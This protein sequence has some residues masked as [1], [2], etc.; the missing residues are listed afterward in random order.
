MKTSI[1]HARAA[2]E[3]QYLTGK[4]C[5]HGHTA[6]R[7]ALNGNCTACRADYQRKRAA[8]KPKKPTPR[9]AAKAAGERFYTGTPCKTCGQTTRYSS[10]G[11]CSR[12]YLEKKRTRYA[13]D[14]DYCE[15][16][17]RAKTAWQRKNADYVKLYKTA[18]Y[19]RLCEEKRRQNRRA[20]QPCPA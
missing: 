20:A 18:R 6:P 16:A 8:A 1:Q 3:K 11:V 13:T 4:P 10:S 19:L 15:R 9:K 5:K 17:K 7:L 2:G 12:C 14:T